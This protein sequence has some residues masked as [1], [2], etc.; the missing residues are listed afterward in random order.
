MIFVS[1][2]LLILLFSCCMC[3]PDIF[4]FTSQPV[5]QTV[6]SGGSVTLSC[7]AIGRTGITYSWYKLGT[8]FN[9]PPG[10]TD[11][12]SGATGTEYEV[13][14][15]DV[16]ESGEDNLFQCKA[17]YG[18]DIILSD[19]AT[20]KYTLPDNIEYDSTGKSYLD[21]VVTTSDDELEE[22]VYLFRLQC[23]PNED[24][25]DTSIVNGEPY[26]V[27]WFKEGES[28]RVE[29]NH[30]NMWTYYNPTHFDSYEFEI[31]GDYEMR[32]STVDRYDLIIVSVRTSDKGKYSCKAVSRVNKQEVLLGSTVLKV[33]IERD[34]SVKP[35]DI[36]T[37]YMVLSV[38]D[39]GKLKSNPNVGD[40]V[41]LMCG[42]A[43]R[44]S[45]GSYDAQYQWK[46]SIKNLIADTREHI[47]TI[48]SVGTATFTC[49]ILDSEC[50]SDVSSE[51]V[52]LISYLAKIN[53]MLLFKFSKSPPDYMWYDTSDNT[54]SH[55]KFEIG[56]EGSL[57]SGNTVFF[58]TVYKMP[59]QLT[60]KSATE[61]YDFGPSITSD[62]S[63]VYECGMS[64]TPNKVLWYQ[65]TTNVVIAARPTAAITP[66]TVTVQGDTTA[67]ITCT[68]GGYPIE[69]VTISGPNFLSFDCL[70]SSSSGDVTC[71][72]ND[73]INYVVNVNNF[74][75]EYA[76]DYKCTVGT[77]W[78]KITT[79]SASAIVNSAFD[80]VTLS[81]ESTTELTASDNPANKGSS[82]TLTC[83]VK[84]DPEPSEPVLTK[85]VDS[86]ASTI[87]MTCSGTT[88]KTCKKVFSAASYTD[89]G[90]YTCN[91][92]NVI[93]TVNKLSSD[94]VSLKIV[95]NADATLTQAP[96]ESEL[97]K[98]SSVTFTCKVEGNPLPTKL[99]FKK[100]TQVLKSY[101]S[102]S[103]TDV[104]KETYHI[105]YENTF[106]PLELLNT[107]DY[108]CEGEND[109]GGTQPD[110]DTKTLTV[111][112]DVTVSLSASTDKPSFGDA[113]TITC[114]ATGG[115]KPHSV[116]LVHEGT[117]ISTGAFPC[118]DDGDYSK[119]C[120]Y[121]HT[122]NDYSAGGT[123]TCTGLNKVAG[124]AVRTDSKSV[125]I[126]VS[127]T[128]VV[129]L[130]PASETEITYGS[131]Y[132][133]TCNVEGGDKPHKVTLN[134]PD[135]STNLTWQRGSSGNSL[136]CTGEFNLVCKY[137][138]S[139]PVYSNEGQ[140]SCTGFN[141]LPGE[142]NERS[143]LATGSLVV[144]KNVELQLTDTITSN[145]DEVYYG[146]EFKITCVA[147]GGRIPFYLEL[148]QTPFGSSTPKDLVLYDTTA[149]KTPDSVT[150]D[151]G[152]NTLTY[153]S[154][155]TSSGYDDIG[156]YKCLSKNKADL[157]AEQDAEDELDIIVV[158]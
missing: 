76:G 53:P 19:V 17:T 94:S 99:I 60:G 89:S 12:I 82:V 77:K 151:I 20:V 44:T 154:S 64:N 141:K 95:G 54:K 43:C 110:I 8:A 80:D 101:P 78:Y 38:D 62:K 55:T 58:S 34:Y 81:Y 112:S 122:V 85:T 45:G 28:G 39:T 7:V 22:G 137:E 97:L 148:I 24:D 128:V 93:N 9:T 127:K 153:V 123:Y 2:L 18:D 156:T 139:S 29:D 23:N 61:V 27:Q 32:L 105:S 70:T 25:F 149:S 52:K 51:D 57:S 92:K 21:Q 49:E 90:L 158:L 67:T 106:N 140:Y 16:D 75:L 121:T 31:A 115:R 96:V 46:D 111:V 68:V 15:A 131:A 14:A 100:G 30:D 126:F 146:N 155:V 84:G 152:G 144:V 79:D 157:M 119:K 134:I 50:N 102:G 33:S 66:T 63:G 86:S 3:G 145:L 71:S 13:D 125:K 73:K 91:G 10:N 69:S 133:I 11:L 59:D 107:G 117:A 118:T 40:K 37:G 5:S 48:D 132:T 130:T 150:V 113:F 116:T 138:M 36:I 136:M 83:V 147:E 26:D 88:T 104:D 98:G 142:T 72:S 87:A 108:S 103:D 42:A 124:N 65:K 74:K 56:C 143:S 114:T 135:S 4:K 35:L 109:N 129:S 120:T 41:L 47:V 1:K 6:N